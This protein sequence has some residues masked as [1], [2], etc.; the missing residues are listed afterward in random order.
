[1][2]E[3]NEG[4]VF[5]PDVDRASD[6]PLFEAPQNIRDVLCMSER[7]TLRY[8]RS[9]DIVDL[10]SMILITSHL[11]DWYVRRVAKWGGGWGKTFAEAYPVWRIIRDIGNGMKHPEQMLSVEGPTPFEDLNLAIRAVPSEEMEWE[12]PNFWTGE[13]WCVSYEGKF[14][15]VDR[16]CMAFGYE[17]SGDLGNG[18]AKRKLAAIPHDAS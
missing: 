6:S 10:F 18:E 5:V 17:F 16:L 9:G 2:D 14:Y 12:N 3:P 13:T 7:A 15:A 4:A 11:A 1:M 8:R